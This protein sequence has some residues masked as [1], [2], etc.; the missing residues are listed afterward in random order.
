[1]NN[2]GTTSMEVEDE[3]LY[4]EKYVQD[5]NPYFVARI[6]LQRKN[7]LVCSFILII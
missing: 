6:R 3:E 2:E 7:E 5:L 4:P 1:M